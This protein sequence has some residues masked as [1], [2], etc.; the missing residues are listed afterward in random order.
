MR[1][2]WNYGLRLGGRAAHF[3]RH[4]DDVQ[5]VMDNNGWWRSITVHSIHSFPLVKN[6]GFQCAFGGEFDFEGSGQ[7]VAGI[8][9]LISKAGSLLPSTTP[10]PPVFPETMLPNL[11]MIICTFKLLIE[12]IAS[13]LV[14]M[15]I[16]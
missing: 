5:S 15:S 10:K 14:S 8:T 1:C 3:S 12:P 11:G 9:R 13:S 2:G 4:N 16:Y 6:G 7:M